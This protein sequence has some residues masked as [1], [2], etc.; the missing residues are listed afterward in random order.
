[1][2]EKEIAPAR[3]ADALYANDRASQAMGMKIEEVRDG[4]ARLTMPVRDDMLNGHRICHGGFLFT[5]ADSAFAFACNTGNIPTVASSCDI[6]FL[7]PAPGGALLTAECQRRHHAGRSG[8]YDTV[9]RA[10][11]GETVAL[12]RGRCRQLSGSII[13]ETGT[14]Q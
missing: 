14:E 13:N 11:D 6:T 12:F 9:I 5:L 2:P 1:M 7:R 3:V 4:Y 10:D 8:V